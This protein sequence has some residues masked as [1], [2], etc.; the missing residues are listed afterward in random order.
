VVWEE[1]M[2]KNI[3][4]KKIQCPHCGHNMH[5]SL[6]TTEGDQNYYDEC[7][8]CCNDIHINMHI[9]Q[10]IDEIELQIDSDDEQV[11]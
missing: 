4:D 7:P 11:F 10:S 5:L 9:N 3:T 6:D 2:L 1:H 8:A